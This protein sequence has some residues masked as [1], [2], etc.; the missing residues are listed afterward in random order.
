MP[1]WDLLHVPRRAIKS[2]DCYAHTS[3]LGIC[4][5]ACQDGFH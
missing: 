4:W 3:D 5:L 2:V 1:E